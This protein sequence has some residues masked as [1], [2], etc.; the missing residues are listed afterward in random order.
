M[1]MC[2]PN[3]ALPLTTTAHVQT[4]HF[5]NGEDWFKCLLKILMLSRTQQRNGR[6]HNRS[7]TQC[8]SMCNYDPPHTHTNTPPNVSRTLENIWK[9]IKEDIKAAKAL[10]DGDILGF[11]GKGINSQHI[12]VSSPKVC[13]LNENLIFPERASSAEGPDPC[14]LAQNPRYRKGPDVCF[15]NNEN[16]RHKHSAGMGLKLKKAKNKTA[17]NCFISK[18]WRLDAVGSCLVLISSVDCLLS[19][20]F[21]VRASL[22]YF[23][24]YSS[25]CYYF[26]CMCCLFLSS[27]PCD[28]CTHRRFWRRLR[29]SGRTNPCAQSA[30][31]LH[32]APHLSCCFWWWV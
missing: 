27:A 5:L 2:C 26:A 22:T 11:I 14:E 17:E 28:L 12:A 8:N 20:L 6:Q 16:V 15:D 21:F 29:L 13:R 32:W 19:L 24:Y 1:S 30:A 23:L 31:L 3:P 10:W 25:I 7:W 18:P 4:Q 9:R